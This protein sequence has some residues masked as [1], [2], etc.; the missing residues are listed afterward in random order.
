MA[1]EASWTR[2]LSLCPL[3]LVL[4]ASL[5][6]CGSVPNEFFPP[7]SLRAPAPQPD[8]LDQDNNRGPRE[9]GQTEN[10]EDLFSMCSGFTTDRMFAVVA[11]QA[12]ALGNG[13]FA[14]AYSY[15]SS[16]FQASVTVEQSRALITANYAVLTQSPEMMP[17]RCVATEDGT[18]GALDIRLDP[19]TGPLLEL[20]Y[21][22]VFEEDEWR[23]DGANSVGPRGIDT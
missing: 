12:Q 20:R 17:Q 15:A 3:I 4:T 1:K 13:N 21:L 14:E 23:I 16:A 6:G 8:G 19:V 22:L 7:E 10:A 5:A 18:R 9:G 2:M 11:S